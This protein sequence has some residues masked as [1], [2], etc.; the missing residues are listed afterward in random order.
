MLGTFREFSI[1]LR[2]TISNYLDGLVYLLKLV[3]S[4]SPKILHLKIPL[5]CLTNKLLSKILI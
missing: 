2:L 1:H 5:S 3:D 4:S